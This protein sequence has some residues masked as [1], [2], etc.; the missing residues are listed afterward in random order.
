MHE[1]A[2]RP[3]GS[4]KMMNTQPGAEKTPRA[5]PPET[6]LL[7]LRSEPGGLALPTDGITLILQL[8]PIVLEGDFRTTAPQNALSKRARPHIWE[9]ENWIQ[10]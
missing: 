8:P 10:I 1:T 6:P 9:A 4:M 3:Q 7:S 2:P 5:L